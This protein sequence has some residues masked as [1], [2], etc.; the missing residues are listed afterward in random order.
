MEKTNQIK[1]RLRVT[2]PN[3]DYHATVYI[4]RY[5]IAEFVSCSE[6]MEAVM[7]RLHGG[8][9]GDQIGLL[10]QNQ[11]DHLGYELKEIILDNEPIK[12]RV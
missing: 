7:E 3:G 11:I 2:G 8:W 6:F 1:T 4:G 10:S 9:S 5:K 12:V